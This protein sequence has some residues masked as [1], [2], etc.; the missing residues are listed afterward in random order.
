MVACALYTPDPSA[1]EAAVF[2]LTP[3]EASGPPV[4]VW[5]DNLQSVNTFIAASTQWRVG[6]SGATGLDYGVLPTVLRL[7]TI[8]RSH[9]PDVFDDIRVLEDEALK[10]I[11]KQAKT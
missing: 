5:P 9:W 7:A 11:R 8:P 4:P 1:Q 3:E 2:G 10:T 6:S